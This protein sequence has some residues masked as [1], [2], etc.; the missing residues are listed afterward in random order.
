[1]FERGTTGTVNRQHPLIRAG[2]RQWQG[3]RKRGR[4]R[5]AGRRSVQ[6]PAETATWT[7][8]LTAVHR[9]D[10][11]ETGPEGDR[12]S[13]A[14]PWP[15]RNGGTG[16]ENVNSV[17]SPGPRRC[18]RSMDNAAAWE[19]RGQREFSSLRATAIRPRSCQRQ[20]ALGVLQHLLHLSAR[21]AGEPREEI[22]HPS[23]PF[24]N[25]SK[26][27]LTRVPL[28]SHSP[29]TFP[30]TRSTAGHSLQSSIVQSYVAR[31]LPTR[32]MRRHEL[33]QGMRGFWAGEPCREKAFH[34]WL[35]GLLAG[36]GGEG[37]ETWHGSSC[38]PSLRF[39]LTTPQLWSKRGRRGW[40]HPCLSARRAWLYSSARWCSAALP[41]PSP[42]VRRRRRRARPMIS[43]PRARSASAATTTRRA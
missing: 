24:K 14:P 15:A 2:A 27:A 9:M 4:G 43:R 40:K 17:R 29:L 11:P 12:G 5:T 10:R 42:P 8:F 21:H 25:F 26:S 38:K 37:S 31:Q 6:Y 3:R 34:K 20:T 33:P 22:I 30:G 16:Q 1:M 19:F 28:N 41:R 39:R 35:N 13:A 23:A 18:G 32:N 36:T 7:G